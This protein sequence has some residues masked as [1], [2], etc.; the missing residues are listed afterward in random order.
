MSL[1]TD[2]TFF[3]LCSF[4]MDDLHLGVVSSF[5]FIRIKRYIESYKA[6]NW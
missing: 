6:R 3:K 2:L 4:T 5:V 1:R